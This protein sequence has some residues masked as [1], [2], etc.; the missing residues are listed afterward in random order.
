M[1]E[2]RFGV[3]TVKPGR[4]ELAR[5]LGL[6]GRGKRGAK[7]AG[8]WTSRVRDRSRMAETRSGFRSREPDPKGTPNSHDLQY[9]EPSKGHVGSQFA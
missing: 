4:E 8:S 5:E 3:I 1:A 2:T 9:D 6:D 7:I